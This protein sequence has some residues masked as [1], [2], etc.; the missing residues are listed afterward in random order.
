[1]SSMSNVVLEQEL[2]TEGFLTIGET[3]LFHLEKGNKNLI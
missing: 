2:K 3:G 1:M